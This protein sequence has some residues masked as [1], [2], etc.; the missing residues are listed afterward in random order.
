MARLSDAFIQ[1]G[2]SITLTAPYAVT[3]GQGAIVGNLFGVAALTIASGIRGEFIMEGVFS[4][5]KT[6]AQVFAEGAIAYW[7]NAAKSVTAVSTGNY[8]IGA[9]SVAAIAG[10]ANVTVRLNG[11]AVPTGA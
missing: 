4:L 3:A 6:A 10:D 7:D 11:Q 1:P 8:R 2:E 5:T 9:A